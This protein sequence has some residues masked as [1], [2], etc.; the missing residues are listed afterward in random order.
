MRERRQ[1]RTTATPISKDHINPE[2]DLK[3]LGY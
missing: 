2:I 3:D 1:R